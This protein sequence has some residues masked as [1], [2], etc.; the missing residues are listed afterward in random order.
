MDEIYIKRVLKGELNAYRFLVRQHQDIAMR[1]AMSIVKNETDAKDVVQSS[2]IQAYESLQKFRGDAK[3]STWLCRIVANKSFR[4]IQK[5]VKQIER[6]EQQINPDMTFA[7]NGG[8][9]ALNKQDLEKLLKDG[10]KLLAAKEALCLQLFYLEEYRLTEIEE[11]T[12]FTKSNIKVLLFRGRKNLYN[13]L[14]TRD[15]FKNT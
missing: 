5:K 1:T 6:Q 11:V 12:G 3:F 10:L 7:D 9:R 8:L 4:F 14:I 15:L 13:I 2:F